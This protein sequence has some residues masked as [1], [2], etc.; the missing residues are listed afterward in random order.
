MAGI[1]Q[2]RQGT[3]NQSKGCFDNDKYNIQDNAEGKNPVHVRWDMMAM[4]V[5]MCI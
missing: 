2:Q 5:R 4:P 1:R 3:G